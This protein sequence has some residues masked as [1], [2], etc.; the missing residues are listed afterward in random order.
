MLFSFLSGAITM[1][2]LVAGLLF[3]RFRH[4]TR[5]SLFASRGD[6]NDVRLGEAVVRNPEH[7]AKCQIVI[8]GCP[9]DEGVERNRGRVGAKLALP[10]AARRLR[11]DPGLGLAREPARLVDAPNH[12][13]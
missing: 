4:R 2:F 3:L 13:P 8:L 7:F 9:Q 5:E 12:P 11:P 6:V 1:G 10:A